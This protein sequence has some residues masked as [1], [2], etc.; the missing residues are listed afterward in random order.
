LSPQTKQPG[1]QEVGKVKSQQRKKP[2]R[3]KLV[4]QTL[5]QQKPLTKNVSR[6]RRWVLV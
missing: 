1:E 5:A 6:E 3:K 2:V 4:I